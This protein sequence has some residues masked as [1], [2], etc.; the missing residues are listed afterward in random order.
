MRTVLA[1]ALSLLTACA[2][3]A[4]VEKE[5]PERL[6]VQ[7]TAIRKSSDTW[8]DGKR[9]QQVYVATWWV[10][11]PGDPTTRV[12]DPALRLWQAPALMMPTG[13]WATIFVGE[14]PHGC[15][16][17]EAPPRFEP[18]TTGFITRARCTDLTDGTFRVELRAYQVI[19]GEV[20]V[21]AERDLVFAGDGRDMA[22]LDLAP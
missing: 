13:A 22:C 16:A 11:G 6:Y 18:D 8:L 9:E 4:S 10:S 21:R 5:K 3:P 1:L 2:T 15:N 12:R 20:Q 7:V 19:E 14:N 17:P